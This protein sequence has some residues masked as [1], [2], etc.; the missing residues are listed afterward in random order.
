MRL[1]FAGTPQFAAVALQAL[2]AQGH[3][4]ALVLTQPDRAAGRGMKLQPSAV[5]SLAQQHGLA[6]AQPAGLRFDGRHGADAQ[7]ARDALRAAQPEAIV[8][9]A[10][11]LILPAWV[12][13]LPRWGCLNIHASLLPRWRGAAPIQR[14]IEA[15]DAETGITI[16]QMDAGLDTGAC[17]LTRRTPIEPDDSAATLHDRLAVLGGS[18]IVDALQR[19]PCGELHATPQPN[20]GATYAHKI[21]THE[22]AL[23]WRCS[24]ATLERRVRAFDPFP[25]AT[26]ND[27]GS[28]LK[29][30]RAA[31]H[32]SAAGA[33]GEV[34]ATL[35][36]PLRVASGD[37]A[38]ELLELQRPGGRRVPA[39]QAFPGGAPL[40]GQGL[41]LPGN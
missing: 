38:L 36:G 41:A 35:P 22:A 26:L 27:R 14:A 8:V 9:A 25:G 39:H 10:Y 17:L 5:K 6:L 15:G 13:E 29:V 16:M 30:W 33:P 4:V 28:V 37:G 34:I 11:G 18:A 2:L 21:Q 12:L 3:D 1:A 20:D 7:A 40:V 19:L 23:D 31:V 24:A 32:P